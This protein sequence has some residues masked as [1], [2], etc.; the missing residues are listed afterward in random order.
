M[1]VKLLNYLSV[2]AGPVFS[3]LHVKGQWNLYKQEKNPRGKKYKRARGP[4][5]GKH[6]SAGSSP[7]T[8][9]PHNYKGVQS[10]SADCVAGL[11][12][13]HS[14][15][16]NQRAPGS[17]SRQPWLPEA[18]RLVYSLLSL[19]SSHFGFSGNILQ[20]HLSAPP[21]V[22]QAESSKHKSRHEVSTFIP[23]YSRNITVNKTDKSV[24]REA[25]RLDG[26]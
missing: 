26:P 16:R 23:E 9:S 19:R 4:D 22:F 1:K 14:G 8:H 20:Q 18:S 17:L 13:C 7:L 12:G 5:Q 2:S 15:E 24:S 25:Y 21:S 3:A 6:T 11:T 10:L